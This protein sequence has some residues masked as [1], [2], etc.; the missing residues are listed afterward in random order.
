MGRVAGPAGI[1]RA[2]QTC[3]P[4]SVPSIPY[5]LWEPS[6]T[7]TGRGGD[8]LSSPPYGLGRKA[9]QS[10]L[11]GGDDVAIGVKRPTRGRA[12]HPWSPYLALLQVGFGRRCVTADDRTLLPSDFNLAAGLDPF[13][14]TTPTF[15]PKTG[16][17]VFLCHFPSP[18]TSSL[19]PQKPGSY[20]ALCPL[21][22][23]LSS[24]SKIRGGGHPVCRPP[25]GRTLA[26]G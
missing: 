15:V 26:H 20:P 24:P 9:P 1:G 13:P 25:P 18:T 23:G 10:A 17:G 6:P 8:H 11:G 21:E 5:Q 22:P 14:P 4:G 19:T 3:K 7:E 2:T 16:G 12:G